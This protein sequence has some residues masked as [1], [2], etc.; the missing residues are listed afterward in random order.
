MPKLLLLFSIA[1]RAAAR[2][3]APP[4]VTRSASARAAS[5]QRAWSWSARASSGHLFN[6]GGQTDLL[7]ERAHRDT[8]PRDAAANPG[9]AHQ[10]SRSASADRRAARDRCR[11]RRLMPGWTGSCD[12]GTTARR[13]DITT[14]PVLEQ[15]KYLGVLLYAVRTETR[16]RPRSA[17]GKCRWS[18]RALCAD[19]RSDVRRQG[20][21]ADVGARQAL[22]RALL[23]P[24]AGGR[25]GT[26]R[27]ARTA[28][29]GRDVG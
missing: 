21:R 11:Q 12:C 22:P 7:P 24:R 26:D 5:A 13:C 6:R 17:R 3:S 8:H 20:A 25:D 16:R 10:A 14:T 28:E 4:Y 18:R 2:S 1:A 23:V 19:G 9:D 15:S 27:R 29:A